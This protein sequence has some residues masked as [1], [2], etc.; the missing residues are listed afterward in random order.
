MKQTIIIALIL[1][2]SGYSTKAEPVTAE[3]TRVVSLKST[4]VPIKSIQLAEVVDMQIM[5]SLLVLNEMFADKIFKVFNVKTG[6]LIGRAINTG[7]GPGEVVVPNLIHFR[8]GNQIALYDRGQSKLDFFTVDTKKQPVVKLTG[9]KK[10]NMN[11]RNMYLLN[12][13]MLLSTGAFDNGRYCI[14]N[15]RTKQNVIS[16]SYPDYSVTKK[17]NP[18]DRFMIYQSSLAVK[19]DLKKFVSFESRVAY[20]EIVDINKMETHLAYSKKYNE[21]AIEL[22]QGYVV[23]KKGIPIYFNSATATDKNIYV[24]YVDRPRTKSDSEWSAGENLL[25]YDWTGKPVVHYKLDRALKIMT[26][27]IKKMQ[28][29]GFC[30]NPVTKEPEVVKYQLPGE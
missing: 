13:S 14:S 5:D 10:I 17:L 3:F 11:E 30:T 22:V 29:Y 26:L 18:I 6:K 8:G 9:D 16:G 27:D 21:P 25:V 28:L 24:I 7:K 15:I 20:F 19:P 1:F 12:D 2:L 4:L 23:P